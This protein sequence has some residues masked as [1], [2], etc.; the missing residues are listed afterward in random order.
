MP[1]VKDFFGVVGYV[2]KGTWNATTNYLKMHVVKCEGSSYSSLLADD[3]G[4]IGNYPPE[5]PDKWELMAEKGDKGNTGETGETGNGIASVE[6]TGT[7]GLIDTYTITFTSG[8]TTTFN[9]SNGNGIINVEKVSTVGL[10][11]TYRIT[12]DNETTFDFTVT[13]GEDGEVTLTQFNTLKEDVED[14]VERTKIIENKVGKVYGVRRAITNNTSPTWERILDSINL[15][16]NATHDGTSVTND[17]DSLYPWSDI[18]SL[19]L[20]LTTGEKKAYYGDV[21]FK[22]DGSNGDV[23]THIPRFWI[24]IYEENDYMYILIADYPKKGFTEIKEFDIQRYLTGIGEDGKL[25]SYS[26]LAGA[27][28]RS[29]VTYRNLVKQLGDDYCLMDWRYFAIQCLYL[30]EYATFNS[31]TALGNGCSSMRHNTND[32]ALIAEENTNRFIVNTTAGNAFVVGQQVK[33][34]TFENASSVARTITSIADYDDGTITGK[35]ITLDGEPLNVTLTTK[36]WT[37]VQ[38]AGQCDSLGMKSGCLIDNQKHNVIYRGIEG[39]YANIFQFVD[40]I[41]IKDRV[42]YICYDPTEYVS[43]KF[44]APYEELGYTNA[45]SNGYAK[46]LGFDINHP[47]AQFPTEIGGGT[48]SG[49]TDYYYQDSGNR[50]ARV[51]GHLHHGAH[52]GLWCWALAYPSSSAAWNYGARV[53]KY[54]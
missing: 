51:G 17:F 32:V 34:G 3:I 18:V 53:L 5:N 23:Y 50:V 39:I 25:H 36:I 43:N 35:E 26:G 37:G 49:T 40:G 12:F 41:N 30:V 11:D 19:N 7:N 22:F 21:D 15:E 13:N 24:K 14:L 48:N 52:C 42:A 8:A 4:N 33:I 6:K 10:V 29:I 38:S 16:A 2:N 9:V 1:N 46:T 31:Q 44:E 54:Q 20:D 27:D 45:S 47:L 28:F